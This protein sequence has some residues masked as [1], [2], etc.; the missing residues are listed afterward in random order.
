V[1]DSIVM[2]VRPVLIALDV[3][4]GACASASDTPG[5]PAPGSTPTPPASAAAESDLEDGRHAAYLT[6]VDAESRSVVADVVQWL[7]GDQAR[8]A[9][10]ADNPD[11]P[12]GPPNDYYIR[13]EDPLLRTLEVA[14]DAEVGLVFL[15]EDGDPDVDPATFE[16]LAG[17]VARD[18]GRA[19][20]FWLTLRDG[21]VTAI[22]E[23]YRP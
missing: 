2:R 17:Y 7:T 16:D 5:T 11:D 23:Q 18:E 4:S 3:A 19:A 10:Q 9:Y 21:V 14:P 8:L 1:L 20:V 6:E 15:T 12:D 13:N 22:E